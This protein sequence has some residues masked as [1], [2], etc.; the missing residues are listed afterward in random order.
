M[1]TW[2]H[3]RAATGQTLLV[4]PAWRWSRGNHN[5]HTTKSSASLKTERPINLHSG[6]PHPL[7]VYPRVQMRLSHKQVAFSPF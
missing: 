4:T 2:V 3:P 5:P 1:A 7:E 6:S